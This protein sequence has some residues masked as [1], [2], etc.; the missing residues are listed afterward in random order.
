MYN[1]GGGGSQSGGGGSQSGGG[2][3]VISTSQSESVPAAL[4][5]VPNSGGS[6]SCSPG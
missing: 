1:G 6:T 2:S 3:T 5:T 4:D